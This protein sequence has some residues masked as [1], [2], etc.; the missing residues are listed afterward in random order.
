MEL[1][2]LNGLKSKIG[3]TFRACLYG[4]LSMLRDLN[5]CMW[6]TGRCGSTVIA[7][8]IMQDGRITWGGELLEGVSK[9]WS[10]NTISNDISEKIYRK[11]K[12]VQMIAGWRPFGFEMKLW[13]HK[14]LEL[15]FDQVY[16]IVQKLGF[17]KHIILERK[18][19]LRQ[20]VS[21]HVAR[22]RG[23]THLKKGQQRELVKIKLNVNED[24]RLLYGLRLYT[25]YYKELREKLPEESL[26]LCYED[27]IQ[28]DPN[29][30]YRKI[31]EHLNY[32]PKRDVSTQHVKTN[33]YKLADVIEN[34]DEVG[35]YLKDTPFHWMVES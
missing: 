8:L 26:Y 29:E 2:L 28:S 14:R 22:A 12:K 3:Y 23:Q 35:N 31:M 7:D 17:N 9:R 15:E 21:W 1:S 11:I 5:I 10:Q 27:D 4:P 6:H 33:P 18:N 20:A 13:H 24:S 32:S 25:D 34:F 16:S 19:Y 30:G